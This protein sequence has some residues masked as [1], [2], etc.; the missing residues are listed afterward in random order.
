VITSLTARGTPLLREW[1]SRC[2]ITRPRARSG[3]RQEAVT[4]L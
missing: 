4:F 2:I 1:M 3:S